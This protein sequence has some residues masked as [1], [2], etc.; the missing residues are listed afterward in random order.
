[1]WQAALW[2]G[3]AG[4]AVLL[5]AIAGILFNIRRNIIGAIMAFGTGVLIGAASFELLA[6]SVNEGGLAATVAGF[7]AG[8]LIFTVVD[9]L[10]SRKG[11]KERKRSREGSRN[12][13]GLAI[14]FGT[15]FDAIPESVILGVSLLESKSV[16]WLLVAAIFISNIPE[17]MSSSVGLKKDGYSNRKILILWLVVLALSAV[18]SFAGYILLADAS[19]VLIGGIGAFAA[20]GV[21]SMVSSTMMPEAYEEGGPIVGLI[22]ASGLLCSLVLSHLS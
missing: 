22:A 5:G 7:L 11:G 16:S 10:L 20:G 8:A 12:S 13:T 2:G 21:V 14:F 19:P 1:M 17:G 15:V 3:I 9:I 6:D 4:S 18:S